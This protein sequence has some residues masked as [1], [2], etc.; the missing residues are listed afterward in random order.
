MLNK[1]KI[2]YKRPCPSKTRKK[3]S[4]QKKIEVFNSNNFNKK[5]CKLK[6]I[7]RNCNSKQMS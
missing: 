2:N 4:R 6:K 5:Y 7:L 3:K 1:Q